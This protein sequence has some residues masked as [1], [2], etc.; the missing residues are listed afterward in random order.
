M[1]TAPRNLTL[2]MSMDD[3]ELDWLPPLTPNGTVTYTVQRTGGEDSIVNETVTT[4]TSYPL[5]N[6]PPSTRFSFTVVASTTGGTSPESNSVS[7]C[8]DRGECAPSHCKLT[9]KQAWN[10]NYALI[11]LMYMSV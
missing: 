8:N 7:F 9:S 4:N 10:H 11:Y 5:T 2:V 3:V 6:Q 1:P